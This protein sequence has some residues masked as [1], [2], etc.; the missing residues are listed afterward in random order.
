MTAPDFLAIG[1]VARDIIPDGWRLGGAAAHA[2]VQ[3][4]RLGL[5]AAVVT[6]AADDLDL[7]RQL[8]GIQVHRISSDITTTFENRYDRGRRIQRAWEQA[9]PIGAE[10]VPHE[11]RKAKLVLLAPLLGEV[12]IGLGRLFSGSLLAYSPQGWLRDVK[13]D[14]RVVGR[15]W[16]RAASLKGGQVLVVSEEDMGGH[17]AALELWVKDVPVVVVTEGTRGARVHADGHWRQIGAFPH[18][19]VDPTGAG[20]VF[21]AALMVSLSENGDIALAA[22]LASAAAA[23]SVGGEGIAAI[24]GRDAIEALLAEYPEVVL[25]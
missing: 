15:R 5:S 20:D 24:A 10:H 11:W 22:R 3:A 19:E 17:D 8:P 25:R 2:A 23:L 21:V 4:Q 7:G 16:A 13:A 9:P 12:P 1:H 18:E 14:H 6:R